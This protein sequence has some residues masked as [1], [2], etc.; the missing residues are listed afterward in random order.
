MKRTAFVFLGMAL[1]LASGGAALA[2]TVTV[3]LTSAGGVVSNDGSVFVGPYQLQVGNQIVNAPCDDF[4]DEIWVGETWQANEIPLTDYTQGLWGNQANAQQ[5]YWAASYL[6][7]LFGKPGYADNDIS[8]AI[9]G[10]FDADAQSS[11]NYS[12]TQAGSLAASA[13]NLASFNHDNLND[14]PGW[15]ILTPIN[16]T[17]SQGGRPQ[18]FVVPG[19]T[20]TP[21]PATL[22][23]LGSGLLAL[24][25]TLRK[26]ASS[27]LA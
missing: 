3:T 14:F 9:W 19:G 25:L 22:V 21:E 26:R 16:G 4:A 13:L 15:Q 11:A 27:P 7:T 17:Q 20:P 6:T 5:E 24:G 18:E 1:V 2:S 12:G 10:L 8:F 23:M